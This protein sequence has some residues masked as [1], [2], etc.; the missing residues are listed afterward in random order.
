MSWRTALLLAYMV[1][2]GVAVYC[3]EQR[4]G[5][6]VVRC[7]A[8]RA[9]PANH[10]IGEGDFDP[11]CLTDP[12]T[13]QKPIGRYVTGRVDAGESIPV[14]MLQPMPL[15]DA[16]GLALLVP[17]ADTEIASQRIDAGSALQLCSS[18][19]TPLAK[20]RLRSVLCGATPKQSCFLIVDVDASPIAPFEKSGAAASLH[21]VADGKSCSG[22][23]Q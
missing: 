5:S 19:G 14:K 1:L 3:A 16:S 13:G 9:M 10:L 23:P 2:V 21:A 18:N 22:S 7:D 8:K 11:N 4:N 6:G 17:A 12:S 20:A 15:L